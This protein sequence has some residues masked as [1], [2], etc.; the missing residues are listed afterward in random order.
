[1]EVV[2]FFIQVIFYAAPY[3]FAAAAGA[4]LEYKFGATVKADIATVKA[5]VASVKAQVEAAIKKV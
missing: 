4:Y 1:M 3:V 2:S 5:D